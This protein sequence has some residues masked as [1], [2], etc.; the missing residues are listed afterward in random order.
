[1]TKSVAERKTKLLQEHVTDVKI[2]ACVEETEQNVAKLNQQLNAI[3]NSRT[4]TSKVIFVEENRKE[5]L[6]QELQANESDTS[7]S[8]DEE[9][10][11]VYDID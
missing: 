8:D 10:D 6:S 9:D 4:D 7:H 3:T 11:L 5:N 2:C 1:M